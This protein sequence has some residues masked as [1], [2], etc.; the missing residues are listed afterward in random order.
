M[1]VFHSEML[2]YQRVTKKNGDLSRKNMILSTKSKWID[3]DSILF[4]VSQDLEYLGR[5]N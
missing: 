3:L 4:L 1:V 5:F 2:V